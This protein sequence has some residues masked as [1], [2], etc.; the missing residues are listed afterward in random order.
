M[1][2][3]FP[4][5]W[6]PEPHQLGAG[7]FATS[8]PESRAVAEFA[9]RHP[10][11][12]AWLSLHTYGGVYIRPS[13]DQPDK[14]MDQEDLALFRQI[15]EWAEG[16]AGYPMVSGFEEFTYE[17]DKPLCGDLSTYAYAQRGAVAMVCE[18]WDF[19]KQAGLDV[20]RPFVFN[21]QRRTRDDV[22]AIARWDREHNSGRVV[23]SWRAFDHPQLG[24]VEIGGYDPRFG[25]WNPPPERLGEVCERQARVLLR[26]AAMAPRLSLRDVSSERLG[27]DLYRVTAIVENLGYLPTNVLSS[28]KGLPW[29]DPVRARLELPALASIAMGDSDV[30]V[31]HLSGWGHF[32]ALS[33]PALAR[34]TRESGRRRVAWVVRGAGRIVIGASCARTG[35]VEASLKLE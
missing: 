6:Q 34:T 32:Q 11:I 29:N 1:N 19:W 13:G 17:P 20:R 24:R 22:L 10:N 33:T 35:R 28:A 2:R 18:L 14:K 23:G 21:Y 16:I 3:N 7:D 30:L 5:G 8:E 27:P 15:E 4:Y 26:I 9:T 25:I 31:G 12:F